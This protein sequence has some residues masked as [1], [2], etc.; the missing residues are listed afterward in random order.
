MRPSVCQKPDLGVCLEV[1]QGGGGGLQQPNILGERT[2][3][4]IML[5]LSAFMLE[6]SLFI[7]FYFEELGHWYQYRVGRPGGSKRSFDNVQNA[8]PVE[9]WRY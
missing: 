9:T 7:E 1:L 3:S 4:N 6:N 5:M 8:R 2:R